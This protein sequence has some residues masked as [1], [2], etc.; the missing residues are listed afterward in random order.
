MRKYIERD[1]ERAG[2]RET[3]K[4]RQSKRE[5][6]SEADGVREMERER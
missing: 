3:E 6:Q 5:R 1:G 2:V 4:E